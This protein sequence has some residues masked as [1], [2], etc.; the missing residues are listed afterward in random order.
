MQILLITVAAAATAYLLRNILRGQIGD[1]IV[2]FLVTAFNFRNSDAQEIYQ[3]VIR[4]NMDMIL[5]GVI[6]ICLVI[7]S[8]SWFTKYFD[9]ISAGM[10]KLTEESDAEITLS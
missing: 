10:D 4:N 9:E 1:R 6:L 7:F 2:R 3:L 5:F 8:V